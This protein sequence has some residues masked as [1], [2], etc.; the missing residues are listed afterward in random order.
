MKLNINNSITTNQL[1]IAE[2]MGDY[3]SSIADNI[4]SAKDAMD[5]TVR[6]HESIQ[7][8][9]NYIRWRRPILQFQGNTNI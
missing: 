7:A 9:E 2:S 6:D 8:I 5:Y 4:G 1:H 3:F